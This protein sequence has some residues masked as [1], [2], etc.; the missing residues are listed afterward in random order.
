MLKCLPI[1]CFLFFCFHDLHSQTQEYTA[2][3]FT[4]TNGLSHNYITCLFQDSKGF[5]W[6]GTQNG[7]NRYDGYKFIEYKHDPANKRSLSA[8]FISVIYED[9]ADRGK[10]LWIGTQGG[11]LNKFDRDLE[12]FTPYM[13]N[14]LDSTS[15]SHNDVKCIYKDSRGVYWIGTNGGGLNQFDPLTGRFKHQRHDPDD[16]FSLTN[17]YIISLCEDDRGYLWAGTIDR[18]LNQI[19]LYSDSNDFIPEEAT[20]NDH[21]TYSPVPDVWEYDPARKPD[22]AWQRKADIPT[23]RWGTS[24]CVYENKIYVLGGIGISQPPDTPALSVMEVYDPQTDSWQTMPSM[25]INRA[26][27]CVSQINAKI[28]ALGGW[29]SHWAVG[30][31]AQVFEEYN[32]DSQKWIR[33]KDLSIPMG[34]FATVVLDNKIYM[35]GGSAVNYLET[36]LKILSVYDPDTDQWT[37]LASMNSPRTAFAACALNNKIYAIGGMSAGAEGG[38]KSVEV[39]DPRTDSWCMLK[40]YRKGR[41]I[42][43]RWFLMVKS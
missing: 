6:I 9:P 35:M 7:L 19:C 10:V 14:P 23:A 1:C 34:D 2:Q 42:L 11:G 18:G 28:Y 25:G 32:V 40:I 39:Y 38:L 31:S 3:L 5:L 41:L 20:A 30:A 27:L 22:E 8:N 43:P 21:I 15:L 16:A 13:H 36:A 33:K 37:S 12:T 29:S 17:D 24:C 4:Q 26:G